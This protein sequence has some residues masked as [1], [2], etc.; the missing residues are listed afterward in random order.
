[1]LSGIQWMVLL[2][3]ISSSLTAVMLDKPALPGVV[4][5]RGVAPPAEG[6]AVLKRRGAEKSRPRSSKVLEDLLVRILTEYSRPKGLFGHLSLR[7]HQ[8]NEGQ[9]VPAAHISVVLTKGRRDVDDAGAVGQGDVVV[10]GDVPALFIRPD[11]IKEGLDISAMLQF[12]S[13]RIARGL[14]LSSPSTEPT[15]ASAI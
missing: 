4:N 1:M 13:R 11:K 2:L 14:V 6:I 12:L 15:R 8:L 5:Q 10:A 3:R 7:V 9:A